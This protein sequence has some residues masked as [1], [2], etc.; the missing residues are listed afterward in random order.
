MQS[1]TS[2]YP[3]GLTPSSPLLTWFEAR[4]T[5]DWQSS[6]APKKTPIKASVSRPGCRRPSHFAIFCFAGLLLSE[7]SAFAAR[8]LTVT[9]ERDGQAILITSYED[10]GRADAATVWRYLGRKPIMVEPSPRVGANTADPMRADLDGDV[11]VIVEHASRLIARAKVR[12]LALV[13]GDPA[14]AE[15]FLP[16]AEVERTARA[17][18][19]GPAVSPRGAWT[20]WVASGMVVFLGLIVWWF[21]RQ[22]RVNP[23]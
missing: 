15:W 9:F 2:T 23:A 8:L 22:L 4:S 12:G 17:A 7:K 21:A 16:A 18:G 20:W 6:V 5:P 19:L 1:A 14:K 13:R 10:G 11:I 3:S